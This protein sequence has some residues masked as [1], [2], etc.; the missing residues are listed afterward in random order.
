MIEGISRRSLIAGGI[1]TAGA[2]S[3]ASLAKPAQAAQAAQVTPDYQTALDGIP[4]FMTT[5]PAP[6]AA[7]DIVATHDY[8]VVVVGAGITGLA[9]TV[10]AANAGVSVAVVQ[11]Q[12]MGVSQG[13][14]GS[15]IDLENSD[16]AAVQSLVD[17]QIS[18]NHYRPIREVVN[19]WAQKS[20]EAWNALIDF[21]KDTEFPSPSRR[22]K[23]CPTA[24][25]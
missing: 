5:V 12:S 17:I 15:G 11:K 2:L 9:A 24:T 22:R 3:A 18:S 7:S 6:V 16:P 21:T 23:R 20:G 14:A 25:A 1:I 13:S 19:T 4:S 8:D 10:A